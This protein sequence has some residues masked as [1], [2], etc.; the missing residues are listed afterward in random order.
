MV[1]LLFDTYELGIVQYFLIEWILQM[2]MFRLYEESFLEYSYCRCQLSAWGQSFNIKRAKYITI[3][4]SFVKR[5]RKEIPKMNPFKE[6]E[7]GGSERETSFAFSYS[8]D[9]ILTQWLCTKVKPNAKK[10]ISIKRIDQKPIDKR[11]ALLTKTYYYYHLASYFV[12]VVPST[13]S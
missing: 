5:R 2:S 9:W 10:R 4:L 8:F 7:E 13:K 3:L 11:C 6:R 12:V 1:C